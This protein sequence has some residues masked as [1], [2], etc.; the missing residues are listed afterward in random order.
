M[1]SLNVNTVIKNKWSVFISKSKYSTNVWNNNWK[2]QNFEKSSKVIIL[3]SDNFI[4]SY[5]EIR[6]T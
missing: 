3:I 4:Y 2:S 1:L 5:F 6:K